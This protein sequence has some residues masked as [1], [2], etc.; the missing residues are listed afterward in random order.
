MAGMAGPAFPLLKLIKEQGKL[1]RSFIP[2]K[3]T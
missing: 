3:L 2:P 1:A